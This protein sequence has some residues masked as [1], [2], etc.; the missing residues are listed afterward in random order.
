MQCDHSWM[1]YMGLLG[2]KQFKDSKSVDHQVEVH[3]AQFSVCFPF[4]IGLSNLL[5]FFSHVESPR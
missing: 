1:K 4:L 2:S 5:I 3:L